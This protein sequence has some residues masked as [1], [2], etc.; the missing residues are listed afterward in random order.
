MP[1]QATLVDVI[2]NVL[3]THRIGGNRNDNTIDEFGSKKAR[4]SVFDSH[5]SPDWRQMAIENIVS[6]DFGSARVDC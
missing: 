5:L 1:T 4:N 6:S 2:S 3:Y